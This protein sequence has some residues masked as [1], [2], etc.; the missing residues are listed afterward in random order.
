MIKLNDNFQNLQG[1]Y[2]FSEIRKRVKEYT[3][4]HPDKKLI[5]MD[6]GDVSLPLPKVCIN[7]MLEGVSNLSKKET[8]KGYG[9]EKGYEFLRESIRKWDYERRGIDIDKD[10]IFISDGA[11]CDLGNLGEILSS[12]SKILVSDPGYPVYK[13]DAVMDGRPLELL[14][15]DAE[16]GFKPIIPTSCPDVILLCF[17]NNPTGVVL[18]KDELQK[19]VDYARANNVLIIYDSAYERYITS[20]DIPHSIYECEDAKEV[21]IEVRSFSKTAGFTGLRC[22]YTVVPYSLKGCFSDG[23]ESTLHSLW[24]R[25]QST[26][27][28]GASYIPQIAANAIYSEEGDKEVMTN[29]DYYMRNAAIIRDTLTE[30]GLECFGGMNAPYV[31]CHVPEGFNSQS[32]F[33]YILDKGS[34]S[35]TPGVGFGPHGE[36]YIRF[37]AFNTYEN[38]IEAMDRIKKLYKNGT[39]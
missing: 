20:A 29:V 1:S 9:P 38:T 22:G 19:W 27:F 18:S 31:W 14:G 33:D 30:C 11:K 17:P 4:A 16:H 26:K 15:L 21:A 37:T 23:K 34:I 32:F 39:L 12:K 2:L 36:G 5:R 8:F 6:I 7:A 10:E 13:D 24:S 35:T 25:R 28:N 3:S